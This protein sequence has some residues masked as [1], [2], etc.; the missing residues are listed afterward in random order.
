MPKNRKIFGEQV[1]KETNLNQDLRGLQEE[2][3]YERIKTE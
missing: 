1:T 3:A 2:V